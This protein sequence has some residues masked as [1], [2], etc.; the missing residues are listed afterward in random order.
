MVVGDVYIISSFKIDKYPDNDD[1]RPKNLTFDERKTTFTKARD[2][3]L[4][5][6]FKYISED[7]YFMSIIGTLL[8]FE[9]IT[10]Y[11]SCPGGKSTTNF[12]FTN[13]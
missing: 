2:E 10:K 6:E 8:D 9:D 5:D 1:A 12:Y 4:L 11:D 7:Y 13:T 3:V